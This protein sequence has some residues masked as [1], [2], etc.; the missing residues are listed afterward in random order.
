MNVQQNNQKS[1]KISSRENHLSPGM[2]LTHR[3]K[4]QFCYQN[5]GIFKPGGV[6]ESDPGFLSSP[7]DGGEEGA[8]EVGGDGSSL[9]SRDG[10]DTLH[11]LFSRLSPV[12]RIFAPLMTSCRPNGCRGPKLGKWGKDGAERTRGEEAAPIF[13]SPLGE[14][15]GVSWSNNMEVGLSKGEDNNLKIYSLMM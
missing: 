10:G 13:M 6:S 15:R 4:E 5:Q 3:I 1:N 8:V 9:F 11:E 7:L 14:D 2:Q 12:S